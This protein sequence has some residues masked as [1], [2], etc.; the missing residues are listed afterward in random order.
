M[1]IAILPLSSVAPEV[2]ETDPPASQPVIINTEQW[3]LV[4]SSTYASQES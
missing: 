2:I 1:M 4:F 3:Q